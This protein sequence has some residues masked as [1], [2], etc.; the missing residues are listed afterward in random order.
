MKPIYTA[1][2]LGDTC[3]PFSCE[4][5]E[6]ELLS[7]KWE[8]KR[9]ARHEY[10]MAEEKTDYEYGR[11]DDGISYSSK[12]F[13]PKVKLLMD[14]LNS[15]FGLSLNG[16]FLNKYDNQHQHL[17]WHADDFDGMRHDQPILVV[18]FGAEREIWIK[19]KGES[20]VVPIENRFLLERG[21]CF[22][23]PIGFQDE[24]LHR[25][26]K[27]DKPCGWRISLTFRSFI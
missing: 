25:I 24:M 13:S 1:D 27:H 12:E 5:I 9:T 22:G 18:S 2:I 17:G 14:N 10:F 20:G 19:K 16:C 15:F 8:T 23:M 21:S 11:K 4:E 3:F 7:L 26:P 6:E